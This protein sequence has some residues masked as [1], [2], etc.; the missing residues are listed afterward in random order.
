[1]RKINLALLLLF[2]T[3]YSSHAQYFTVKIGGG[4]AWSGLTKTN[5]IKGF[6]PLLSPDPNDVKKVLDPAYS[7]IV[8]FANSTSYGYIDGNN[9]FVDTAGSR[10]V[11][12][13]SYGRG[14]NF[15]AEVAYVFNPYIAIGL[16]VNYLF[17]ATI[18][19]TQLY[20]NNFPATLG[21][22]TLITESTRAYGL[23]LLPNVTIYGA[24]PQWKVKPYVR[25]GL[26]VP[27]AGNV[28]H[29]I[30]V[31][32]PNALLNTAELNS[33]LRVET[34]SKFSVGFNAAL[35]V[36]VTPI[37]L[38]SIFAEVTNTYLNVAAKA[39]TLTK[40]TVDSRDLSTG[41]TTSA[42]RLKGTGKLP[43]LI[44]AL[45]GDN[46]PLTQYSR[47]IEFVDDLNTSSNTT[48]YGK[49][50]DASGTHTND[51]TYVNEKANHEQIRQFAPFS[52]IGINV[53]ISFNL[54]KKIFKDPFGKKAAAAKA[55]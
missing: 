41:E 38:I 2:V 53:G 55:K 7:T 23:N 27:I 28:V 31:H 20:G 4:Y 10:S 21:P 6:Q 24:K 52:N 39:S 46:N 18:T 16:G 54:S 51:P 32:S 45:G 8:D 43:T 44:T 37:P 3:V 34:E 5:N 17:G 49:Q 50:R 14:A 12:H 26:A 15:S 36:S 33:D 35:G 11:I 25:V 42:D 48:D 29:D 30:H 1:M 47:V 40:Y 19:S 13:D 9:K 22:N